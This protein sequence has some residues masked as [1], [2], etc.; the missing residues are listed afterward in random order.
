M[1]RRDALLFDH[2]GVV[3]E[4]FTA[5]IEGVVDLVF[6]LADLE[7]V[8]EAV[9]LLEDAARLIGNAVDHVCDRIHT[10]VVGLALGLIEEI[11]ALVGALV[12]IIVLELFEAL[13]ERTT[14]ALARIVRAVSATA[15]SCRDSA[16][17]PR[18]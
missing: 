8:S 10:I 17:L 15:A 12:F 5:A 4:E 6:A 11:L 16:T 9:E 7:Y 18:T 13:V 3:L 14:Q 1:R 2:F